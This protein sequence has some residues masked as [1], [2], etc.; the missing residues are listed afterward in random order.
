MPVVLDSNVQ[1][2][3]D[4]VKDVYLNDPSGN[5]W[6]FRTLIKKIQLAFIDLQMELQS[7]NIDAIRKTSTIQTIP[8]VTPPISSPVTMPTQPIDLVVPL[9]MEERL[10]GTTDLFDPMQQTEWEPDDFIQERLRYWWWDQET[11]QFLGATSNRDVKL[12]YLAA[13]VM[14]QGECDSLGVINATSFLAPQTAGYAAQS[15]G[16]HGRADKFFA[17]AQMMLAKLININVKPRQ[18]R[19]IRRLPYR[20]RRVGR[21]LTLR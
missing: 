5:L 17:K 1:T 2:L 14:P 11:I 4:Q 6:S 3:M 10:S 9:E 19:P 12:H 7:N 16:Q 15:L 21:A 20:R 8:L 13:P 18:D